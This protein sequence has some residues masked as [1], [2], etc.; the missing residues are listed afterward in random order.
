MSDL[1]LLY[2]L[3]GNG[4]SAEWWDDALPYFQQHQVVPLELPGFGNNPQPPCE[5]LAAYADALLAA[6]VKGSAIVAVGVNALLVIHALQR[7]PGHFCRSVLLAPVGA[8]LWQRRL[9]ALMS[10]L[11]IRKTIHWLLA[12]KPTLFAH[13]F[14]KQRWPAAHYQR[15]GSGYARCRAFVPYWDLL[16]ADTAL[17]LLE[18]VQDPVELVWGDQDEVLGIEQAAAWSAILARADLSISLKPGWGHYPWIDAPAEFAQW[19]ES[20]ERGFVAHTKGGRLRL[21]A[22]AGQPVPEALSLVQGDDSALPAFLASQPD[23]IWAVRSSSFGEDQA[24][25][26]NAGLSTTFLR[27]PDHNVPARVAELH[28]AGVEEVV[29][30][31][32]ITPVL[33]GIAFVRHLSVELEWVEGHL[34]SLADGQASPERAIISRL[35]AA[36]SS[37]GFKPSHGLTEEVLWDFLQGVLRVF[38]YVPGDVEWAWDGR[39]LWL[40]QYRPIS[41]YGWRRHLTAA[42]IAEILP[43]QPSRLVEYAQRRAAGS[44]PAI[45]A[46]WDSRVLQ[47][48]EPFTALFGAASYI[49][50]DL[51]LARLADWGIAS[52]SYADE[53]GGATPHLP[54]RPLRLLRSLPVFLRMQRVA[55]GHLLTLEKQ[56]HRFDRELHALTAQGADG[57]Q[58]ADWFT[59]FYVFVVQGNL[60]IATS[61]A[62]S[63][64]DLLGRPPTAYDD[65]EHCPHRL[66]WETDPATQ[67]PAATDLPLQA[68]PTWPGFIR[69][70]HR[71]GLPGMRGYY[72]Q[73]REWYRDNL[74]RL[75]FRLHHAMPGAD[76]EH[77]FAPHPDI[78]SRTGSFWQDGREGTEQ[79][80]GFMIYPGQVQGI[81]GEDIL[82]EDTLDPGRHAHYQNARAVIARMGGRLSHGSTLLRELRKPSAVLPQVDLAWVGREVLYVDGELRLVEGQA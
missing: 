5:D 58:L 39:Q 55:R 51:F 75:F 82:L 8:F 62:S 63:G 52:S 9:P 78:R 14:S 10:P 44:I 65:L 3:A 41:D 79:A 18:W 4:S 21:A 12:N 25:A 1:P 32:F 27:E 48:N 20:G 60:C 33:S 45:M 30:Q 2:L 23:A 50:N 76:R 61:L 56:L 7:Q 71:A 54:W 43:P 57:Q 47:D 66:P 26:A 16:R 34:E 17:P 68:F 42:N 53:V 72:L 67:R 19:L 22:I 73:V 6:T 38:H 81:L 69:I 36:W 70:A 49:N 64:G 24:D 74:M 28:N 77:W 31:R 46:R 35:G 29:V 40:L 15:M 80:T 59:R 13:K 11:P 37:G